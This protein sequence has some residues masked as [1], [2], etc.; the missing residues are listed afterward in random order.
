MTPT[1][2]TPNLTSL[3]E[4]ESDREREREIEDARLRGDAMVGG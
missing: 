3:R 4:G 2:E 1:P